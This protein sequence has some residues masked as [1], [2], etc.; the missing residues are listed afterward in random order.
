MAANADKQR[1]FS[2]S[3]TSCLQVYK[4]FANSE[5]GVKGEKNGRWCVWTQ[6]R[7]GRHIR[8]RESGGHQ[9]KEKKCVV[10]IPAPLGGG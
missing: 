6:K 3:A 7:G 5:R 4:R 8:M 9:A 2:H 10:N 1:F